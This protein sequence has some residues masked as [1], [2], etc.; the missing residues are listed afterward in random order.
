MRFLK[1]MW[2]SIDYKDYTIEYNQD[3]LEMK[4]QDAKENGELHF[5][6][7]FFIVDKNGNK[8]AHVKSLKDARKWIDEHSF[9]ARLSDYESVLNDEI[10]GS[11]QLATAH[12]VNP[13]DAPYY[14]EL[15]PNKLVDDA[16]Q[17][18]HDWLEYLDDEDVKAGDEDYYESLLKLEDFLNKF[19]EKEVKDILR[20][21]LNTHQGE[22][23]N[24]VNDWKK[25]FDIK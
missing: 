13:N 11:L 25:T 5:T 1:E 10:P 4:I 2:E 19:S 7:D 20:K 22:L 21:Y 23:N 15:T 9:Q 24:W 12:F 16:Y 6:F 3:D 17:V 14:G 18:L 8:V